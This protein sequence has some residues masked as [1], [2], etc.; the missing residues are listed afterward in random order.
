MAVTKQM[1]RSW[2]ARICLCLVLALVSSA[3]QAGVDTYQYQLPMEPAPHFVSE[4]ISTLPA[5]RAGVIATMACGSEFNFIRHFWERSNSEDMAAEILGKMAWNQ[6]GG[7]HATGAAL[8]SQPCLFTVSA[9][10]WQVCKLF[11]DKCL[12]EDDTTRKAAEDAFLTHAAWTA[13]TNWPTGGTYTPDTT[14]LRDKILS[15]LPADCADA[16]GTQR[17]SIL[18]ST[19]STAPPA[20]VR[21]TFQIATNCLAVQANA[22]LLQM[23]RGDKQVGTDGALVRG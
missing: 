9:A 3:T 10:H 2:A 14:P 6:L 18:A 7:Q 16:N 19:P 20:Q 8:L 17:Y 22:A 4:A 23:S 12:S 11:D 1:T 13:L 21:L 15:F 5:R